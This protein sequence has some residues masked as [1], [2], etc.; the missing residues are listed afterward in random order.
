MINGNPKFAAGRLLSTPG[1]L[2]ALEKA[3]VNPSTL[4]SRHVSGDWGDMCEED[5]QANEQAL[6]D[7]SRIFSAYVLKTTNQKVWAIT[8][9]TDDQGRR[10]ATTILLPEEY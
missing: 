1:A 8:E 2:E 4:L 7:G 3:G 5:K 9:A 10:A 6:Q